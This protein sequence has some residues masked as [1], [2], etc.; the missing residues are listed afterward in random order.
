M[1][2]VEM[3]LKPTCPYC[4]RAG[5]LLDDKVGDYTKIDIAAQ[6]E[7]RDGMIERANGSHTVPQIFINDQ[8]IGGCDDL[9]ALNASGGLD[10]LLK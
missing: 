10:E 6:P 8:H 2:K 4:V 3:Y 1:A 7:L 5:D 9:M